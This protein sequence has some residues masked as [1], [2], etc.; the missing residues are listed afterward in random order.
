MELLPTDVIT[1]INKA[2]ENSFAEVES[3]NKSI[4]EGG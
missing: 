1:I 3:K 4:E 2:W